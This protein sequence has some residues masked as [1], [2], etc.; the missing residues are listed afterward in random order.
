MTKFLMIY[1][2]KFIVSSLWLFLMFGAAA[3]QDLHAQDF[4]FR[5]SLTNLRIDQLSQDQVISFQRYVQAKG[6][7]ETEAS[8]YLIQKGLSRAEVDKLRK[9]AGGLSITSSGSLAGNFEMMD[10]YFRLR[11]SLQALSEETEQNKRPS[12]QS[13]IRSKQIPD[14]VLFGSELFA[15]ARLRFNL[16]GQ[17]VPPTDYRVGPGDVLS[18]LI[19]GFQEASYELKVQANGKITMPY[20]GLIPVAGLTLDQVTE[21]LKQGLQSNGYSKLA[22]G[23]TKLYVSLADFRQIQIIVVGST[24]PGNFMVPSVAKLFHVMHVAG[25]PS[26]LS[27]YRNIELLRNGKVL[28]KVD[29]Y[30]LLSGGDFEGNMSL[31][32]NDV[33]YFPPYYSRIMLRGEVRRPAFFEPREGEKFRDILA[34]A[35]GFTAFAYTKRVWVERV[36]DGEIRYLTFEGDSLMSF[37]PRDGDI[38]TVQSVSDKKKGLI[39]L[40]GAVK[41]SGKYA[42]QPGMKLSHLLL[43]ADKLEPTALMSRAVIARRTPE[44]AREYQHFN[45]DSVKKGLLDPD[46]FDGDSV[47][48][49]SVLDFFPRLPVRVMGQ[50]NREQSLS[51]GLGMTAQDAIFMA[52]GFKP[53]FAVNKWIQIARRIDLD[54]LNDRLEIAKVIRENSDSLLMVR[55]SET[56][57]EEGDVVMV[58]Q[59][60]NF[61]PLGMI[62]VEGS[63]SLPGMFPVRTKSENVKDLIERAGGFSPFADK[64]SLILIRQNEIPLVDLQDVSSNRDSIDDSGLISTGKAR[65]VRTDTVALN[66]NTLNLRGKKGFFSLKDGDRLIVAEKSEFVRIQG[67]VNSQVI[68]NYEGPRMSTYLAGAGGLSESGDATRIYVRR[69]NGKMAPT[70]RVLGIITRYPKIYPGDIV[71]VPMTAPEEKQVDSGFNSGKLLAI[72]SLLMSLATMSSTVFNILR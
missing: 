50:V 36:L 40:S 48:V 13:L 7:S 17:M 39:Q 4:F 64:R 21:K 20:A 70:K 53:G 60:P 61:L 57:L 1:Q 59:N 37:E 16:E 15:G 52:G 56:L 47:I 33:L 71:V 19:Y 65:V 34:H 30:K 32:D 25:G 58:Y 35:G 63:F 51:W 45:M 67:S 8:N 18:I 66:W 23:Q 54:S 68:L 42:F 55:A 22:T 10:Q 69:T 9:R 24:Q 72:S 29:L 5:K 44:G 2:S 38:I 11:D 62:L 3:V 28:T 43:Q 14:S 31:Q 41:R 27:T 6:M 26:S 49:G 46:L 12:D